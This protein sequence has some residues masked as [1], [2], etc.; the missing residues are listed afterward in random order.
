MRLDVETEP[1]DPEREYPAVGVLN[2]GRGLLHREPMKGSETK[3]ASLNRIR[4]GQVGYSRRKAFEG[5]ITVATGLA[6]GAV[7]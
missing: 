4:P 2:R 3:Y 1:V 6:D 7:A 5:A